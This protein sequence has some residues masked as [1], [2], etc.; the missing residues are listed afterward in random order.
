MAE[1]NGTET[2]NQA[3][4]N[5]RMK[6]KAQRPSQTSN[7]EINSQAHSIPYPTVRYTELASDRFKEFWDD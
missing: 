2:E 5:L 7:R 3:K 1:P 6:Q 4:L